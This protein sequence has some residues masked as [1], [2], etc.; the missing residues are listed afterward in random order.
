MRRSAVFFGLKSWADRLHQQLPLSKKESQRLLTA[1]TSSFRQQLDEEHFNTFEEKRP[2]ETS[3][4]TPLPDARPFHSSAASADNH[5]ASI[6]TSP[7]LSSN[8]KTVSTAD[9]NYANASIELQ[10]QPGRDPISLLEEH[11]EKDIASVAVT[12]LCLS[13][14]EENLKAH[15]VAKQKAFVSETQPGK[16]ALLVLWAA[17]LYETEDFV[18]DLVIIDLLTHALMREGLEQYLWDWIRTDLTLGREWHVIKTHAPAQNQRLWKANYLHRWKGRVLRGMV[19]KAIDGH[20]GVP[21][22]LDAAIQIYLKAQRLDD[23]K[24]GGD[25]VSSPIAVP[26]LAAGTYLHSRLTHLRHAED[27]VDVAM[28]DAFDASV[29]TTPFARGGA[30]A[31]QLSSPLLDLYHPAHSDGSV[32]LVAI[33]KLFGNDL[34]HEETICL[35]KS[36]TQSHDLKRN[37]IWITHLTRLVHV[38]RLQGRHEDAQWSDLRNSTWHE[39]KDKKVGWKGDRLRRCEEDASRAAQVL[40]HDIYARSPDCDAH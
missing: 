14:F 20:Y 23:P 17:K 37:N 25:R 31:Y 40:A 15:P 6:L 1:L 19:A 4:R 30:T 22:S 5:L 8:A 18:N 16:R 9:Q 36:G 38:L 29:T 3:N 11:H 39:N 26:L 35:E 24:F 12:R 34:D 10:K 21:G 13:K 7:L 2:T 28:Y 27:S 33:R 32:M